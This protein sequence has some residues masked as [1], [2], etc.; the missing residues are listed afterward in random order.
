MDWA[1]AVHD[2]GIAWAVAAALWAFVWALS[3]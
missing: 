2:I 3:R 1:Q